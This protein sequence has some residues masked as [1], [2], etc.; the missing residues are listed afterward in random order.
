MS[1]RLT[2]QELLDLPPDDASSLR[3]DVTPVP[4]HADES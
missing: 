4:V 1:D 3:W 2:P